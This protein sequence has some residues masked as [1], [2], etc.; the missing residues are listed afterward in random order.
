MVLPAMIF[1][2][3]T[4]WFQ[5]I[6]YYTLLQ[7]TCAKRKRNVDKKWFERLENK[8][9]VHCIQTLKDTS[10]KEDL[11]LFNEE[12]YSS[13][14]NLFKVKHFLDWDQHLSPGMGNLLQ[15]VGCMT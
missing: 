6:S 15:A 14:T 1:C 7:H 9:K 2:G 3:R 4:Q 12:I 11:N 8:V 5:W 13:H 10:I